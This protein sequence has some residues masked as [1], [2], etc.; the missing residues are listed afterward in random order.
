MPDGDPDAQAS[1]YTRLLVEYLA[2]R[3]VPC[4]RCGYNLRA[5]TNSICP[6]CGDSLRLQ[7]GLVEPR[8]GAYISLV[9]ACC[10]GLGG[11]ALFGTIALFNAPF[12]W[13]EELAASLLLVQLVIAGALLP[14]VLV[15]RRKLRA[16]S[17]VLQRFLAGAMWFVVSALSAGIVLLFDA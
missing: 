9:V 15:R 10:V 6:E 4:P 16:K 5:L 17:L 7:V 14:V 1:D 2:D 3:D 13:W 11:S 8:L 12:N